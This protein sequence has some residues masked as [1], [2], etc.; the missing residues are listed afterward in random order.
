MVS[1]VEYVPVS[2]PYMPEADVMYMF[3]CCCILQPVHLSRLLAHN[4]SCQ[5]H[6]VFTFRNISVIEDL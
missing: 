1:Y 4:D 2:E 3:Y 5:L 6:L